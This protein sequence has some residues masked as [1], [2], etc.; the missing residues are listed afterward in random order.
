MPCDARSISREFTATIHTGRDRIRKATAVNDEWN[1][2]ILERATHKR[3]RAR[4]DLR[5]LAP[6]IRGVIRDAETNGRVSLMRT[7]RERF[8]PGWCFLNG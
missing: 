2:E 4:I 5:N 6:A 1:N 3:C 8:C 7:D